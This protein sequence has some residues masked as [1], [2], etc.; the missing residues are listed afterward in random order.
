[1]LIGV[2][3]DT[4]NDISSIKEAVKFF[5]LRGANLVLH[6]GDI[7]SASAAKEFAALKCGFKAVFGNSDFE[8]SAL[9]NVISNFGIIQ[10][11][12]FEF[13]LKEKKFVMSHRIFTTAAGKYDYIIYG[14][15][16]IPR[17]EKIRET[18]FLNPGE[19]C[20][21]RYG[22]RTVALINLETNHCEIFD[23]DLEN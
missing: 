22:R 18:V 2:I 4:H 3:S 7:F 20:G 13:T 1:M 12:P 15:T 8:H 10:N 9:E 19:A 16:H 14:H 11:A 23:L 6:C 5:N 21:W 17:I